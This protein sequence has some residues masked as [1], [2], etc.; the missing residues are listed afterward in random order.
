VIGSEPRL[1]ETGL[2]LHTGMMIKSSDRSFPCW[3]R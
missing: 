3:Q 2:D 1:L